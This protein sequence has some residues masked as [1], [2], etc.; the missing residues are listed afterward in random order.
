[1]KWFGGK[2]RPPAPAPPAADAPPGGAGPVPEI[3]RSLALAELLAELRPEQRLS[4]LDLGPAV[5]SNLEFLSERYRCRLRIADLW[6]SADRGRRIADPD[7]DPAALMRDLVPAD[8]EPLDLILGWDLVN[9]LTKPQIRALAECL[10]PACRLGARWFVMALAGQRI[11][12]EPL[13]Y[14]LREGGDLVYRDGGEPTRPGPRYRPAEIDELTPGFR[15]DR[16]YLL[17]HGV[18]EYLLVRG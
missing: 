14:E 9:Y 4:V 3:H 17:R 6:S 2:R 15:V 5:G 10:A 1:M 16:S 18:Q 11:P 8:G 7:V 12:R 13:T